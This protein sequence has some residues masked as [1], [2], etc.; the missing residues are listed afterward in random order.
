MAV[1][2]RVCPVPLALTGEQWDFLGCNSSHSKA[3]VKNRSDRLC[4][5]SASFSPFAMKWGP[6]A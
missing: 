3:G 5:G 6:N 1:S 4:P 2:E